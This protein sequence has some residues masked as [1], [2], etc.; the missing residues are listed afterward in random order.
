[1]DGHFIDL[2]KDYLGEYVITYMNGEKDTVPLYYGLNIGCIDGR[3]ELIP[4][5]R[6]R[7][8]ANE[9]DGHILEP[10][11]T[12]RIEKLGGKTLYTL[13]VPLKAEA[14]SIDLITDL[15]KSLFE[16]KSS[17]PPQTIKNNQK[18]ESGSI[19]SRFSYTCE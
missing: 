16:W 6:P 8:V 3:W 9:F 13:A 17:K 7:N 19:A 12:C 15:D 11:Y 10:S 2:K 14:E 18:T 1:M 4:S 5:N